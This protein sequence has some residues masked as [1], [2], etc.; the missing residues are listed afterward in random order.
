MVYLLDTSSS[1]ETFKWLGYFVDI[2]K[3][4]SLSSASDE[5][6]QQQRVNYSQ[7]IGGNNRILESLGTFSKMFF[8]K[9]RREQGALWALETRTSLSHARGETSMDSHGGFHGQFGIFTRRIKINEN[10]AEL[11]GMWSFHFFHCTQASKID[12][13]GES[14]A[15]LFA[16]GWQSRKDKRKPTCLE[17]RK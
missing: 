11:W 14:N 16:T 15:V 5:C 8:G 10:H 12:Q 3:N 1:L 9:T 4:S 13:I 17:N 7:S 6:H 2:G